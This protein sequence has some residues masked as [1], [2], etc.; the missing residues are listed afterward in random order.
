M[1][2]YL[3]EAS[4]KRINKHHLMEDGYRFLIRNLD[5]KDPAFELRCDLEKQVDKNE[6]VLGDVTVIVTGPYLNSEEALENAKDPNV[7][8]GDD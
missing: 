2:W 1:G 5:S 4:F 6:A 7:K 3:A 8:R